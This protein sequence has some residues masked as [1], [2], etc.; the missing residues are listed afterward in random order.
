MSH[1]GWEGRWKPSGMNKERL[2]SLGGCERERDNKA[3]GW[4]RAEAKHEGGAAAEVGKAQA[5]NE[6]QL[7]KHIK[8]S[9]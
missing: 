3:E 4:Q 9:I 6:T 1:D 2:D 8:G 7:L 5:G